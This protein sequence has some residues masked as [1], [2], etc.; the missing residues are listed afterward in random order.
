MTEQA[1]ESEVIDPE[2]MPPETHLELS[3][4]SV[5]VTIEELSGLPDERG[6]EIV[7]SRKKI[8]DSLRKASILMTSPSDWLLF[9]TREGAVTAFLQ[10]SGCKRI[11]QIWGISI[12]PT[13][14]F[15]KL[16]D[17]NTKDFAYRCT[18]DGD[19]KVT[20]LKVYDIEGIRYSTEDFCKDVKPDLKKE[21]FVKL[22]AVANRDGN[23]IRSLTGMKSVALEYIEDV[24][25]GTNK[26]TSLCSKGKGYGTQAER[27]GAQ[28]QEAAHVPAGQEPICEICQARAKFWP[29]G[30]SRDSKKPYGAFWACPSREHKW[31]VRDEDF[32]K[33]RIAAEKDQA[34]QEAAAAVARGE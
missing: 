16:V 26:K 31:S 25:K 15:Q 21:M 12:T 4:P 13:G 11:W 6:V 8:L 24:W 27:Q 29:A 3:K 28:V 1:K 7:E 20:G 5:P 33:T 32:Q 22:A 34:Q 17:D 19:C 9:R 18:A 10:D 23:I 14:E 30:I 2:V